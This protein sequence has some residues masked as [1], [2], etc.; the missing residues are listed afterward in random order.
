MLVERTINAHGDSVGL[1]PAQQM[2]DVKH[3]RR[4]TLARVL[5]SQFPVYPDCGCMEYGLKFDPNR[6]VLPFTRDVEG[7]PVPGDTSILDKSGVNLPSVR[8]ADF[9]PGIYGLIASV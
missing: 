4:V 7:P 9:V 1:S 3:E 8:H 6:G 2:S 5:S